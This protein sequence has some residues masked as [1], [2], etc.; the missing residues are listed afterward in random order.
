MKYIYRFPNCKHK[1]N[2]QEQ[3][4][5]ETRLIAIFNVENTSEPYMILSEWEELSKLAAKVEVDDGTIYKDFE[6][7]DSSG[8]YH[9]FTKNGIHK[10]YY[11][12]IDETTIPKYMLAACP[13]ES[14]ILPNNVTIISKDA[15]TQSTLSSVVNTNNI[16]KCIGYPFGDTPFENSFEDGVVYFGKALLGYMGEMPDNTEIIVKEGTISIC[17][18]A[19]SNR[20]E[21]ISIIIPN[22]VTSI[23]YE[24]FSLCSG[25]TS[26][27]I[28]NSVTVI[29]D[30]IFEGCSN[31]VSVTLPDN[32]TSIKERAFKQCTSLTS[33]IIPSSVTTLGDCIFEECPSLTSLSVENGNTKYDSRDNCNAIIETA[34]N[35]LIYG[36]KT[37]VIPNSVIALGDSAFVGC[38]SLTSI[39][40]PESIITLGDNVFAACTSLT[41]ITIPNSVT[42]IGK[43]AFGY[44]TS[45]SLITCGAATA[46]TIQYDT[47]LRI[48]T[49]GTL[50]VPQG[51]T[52]YNVWMGTG[53]YYLGS[54][55]WTKVEQ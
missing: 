20:P 30:Y 5:N 23:G 37:T 41:S 51:S 38:T 50:Y 19:F 32:I 16:Q 11:T 55:R 34:T 49:N 3:E 46:P 47:F 4:N 31:L 27:I 9:T 10:V 15:F 35:T 18:M 6:P 54:C 28:P 29:E 22:S 33:I 2:N 1:K 42:N 13:I 44:C 43:Y 39:T 45:L 36:C 40:I 24:A 14:I 25:L 48:K 7:G 21:L 17:D 8:I 52:G 12:L 53:N 26:I